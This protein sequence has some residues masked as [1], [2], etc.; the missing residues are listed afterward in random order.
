[1]IKPLFLFITVFFVVSSRLTGFSQNK[2]VYIELKAS[3]LFN[4][5]AAVN[6]CIL[7]YENGILKDSIFAKKAKATNITVES[8][9]VYSIVFK[10]DN[11]SEKLVIVNTFLPRGITDLDQEPLSFLKTME[12][13]L[14]DSTVMLVAF[15]F[16]A[17]IE[18]FKIPFS[19]TKIQ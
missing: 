8:D 10:K 15:A 4:D 13:T 3:A 5:V 11:G 19:Y 12:Y 16:F 14:S 7:V 6:Y 2:P 1:M 9:K 17:N 18:S